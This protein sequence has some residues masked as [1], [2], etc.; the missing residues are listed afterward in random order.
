MIQLA[1]VQMFSEKAAIQQNLH[2]IAYHLAEAAAHSADV[3]VLPE[4]SLTGYTD[5]TRYPHA[6][7]RLDGP[8]VAA[9]LQLTQPYDLT[10][11]AG[12]IEH[13]P[14]GKPFI[15]HLVARRGQ[16]LGVYRKITIKDEEAAWF[17][18]G[19]DVPVFTLR[20]WTFGLAIC[21]DIDNPAVFAGCR[22]AGAQIVFE[23]AAP[24]LYGEQA[25]RNWESGYRWWEGK[26]REQL[27]AYARDNGLWIAVATQAGRTVDEDFPG[28]GY[29]FA[30]SGERIAATAGWSPGVLYVT[31][32][33]S[34]QPAPHE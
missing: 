14:A 12:L 2:T 24:G 10:L 15:T 30:P 18:P 31:A 17:S 28:G 4:M 32:E 6:V 25:G 27:G 1:L 7:L 13:N 33:M 16:L 22:Q 11:L 23:V 29:L 20:E 26:C 21:A 5:P 34:R 19:T 9:L 8:E 3:L